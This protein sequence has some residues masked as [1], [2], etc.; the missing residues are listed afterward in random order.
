MVKSMTGFGRAE[1]QNGKYQC[2]AEIR[3]VNNRFIEINARLPKS[4]I[5]LE[6]PLKKLIKDHC[7]RGSFDLTL[8]L[9]QNGEETAD[10]VLKA[11]LPLARQY[12]QAF[13][14]IRDALG[15]SSELD[16][17]T[18]AGL[19]DLVKVEPFTLDPASGELAIQTVTE[20]LAGLQQMRTEE[21][22]N[23]HADISSR[24]D[25]IEQLALEI[26]NRQGAVTQEYQNRLRE[27]VRVLTEGID[28]D[29][30]RL[31]Q[32]VAL[33][34]DRADVTEEIIR[35]GSHLKQFRSLMSQEGP[36]G[37]KLEFITQEINREVNTIGSKTV[38]ATVS[39]AVIDIKSDLEKIREQLQNIE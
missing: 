27:R 34:A 7:A 29:P 30:A 17:N 13:G 20:A 14:E 38:D 6:Q 26:R 32:E 35:L 23:L 25:D 22:G 36:V 8:S 5:E 39:S 10:L 31:A 21:G 28:L 19:R 4:F 2:K 18:L 37:R 12:A 33:L 1:K 9:E 16:I 24:I 11:N 3:S 15:L